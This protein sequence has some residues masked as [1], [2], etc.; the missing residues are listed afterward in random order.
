VGEAGQR[1]AAEQKEG[2]AEVVQTVLAMAVDR[3]ADFQSSLV[4][5]TAGGEFLGHTF[6]RQALPMVWDYAE[7]NPWADTSG[8]WDG[9]VNW[10]GAILEAGV[11]PAGSGHAEAASASAHPLPDSSVHALNT[12][13]PYYDVEVKGK[14]ARLL[15]V[16]ERTRHLFGKDAAGERGVS[17]PW[18]GRGKKKPQ[19]R[20][21]FEHLDEAEAAE[22]GWAD[23]KGPPPGS[24]TL[25]RLH[26]AMILFGANRGE[27]LKRFLLDEGVGKEAGFWS[28][29][30]SLSY[31]Y[32]QGT[33][34]PARNTWAST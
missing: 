9:A 30:R 23:L 10:V 26:Q 22:G 17:T 6:T 1:L 3:Q 20:T 18:H 24:T 11:A 19:Q 5:W 4:T 29:A 31:L 15:P 33:N 32:P 28:L 12:D 14:T 27:L 7:G 16:A 13:P 8:N 34:E 2:L 21:L 25:D